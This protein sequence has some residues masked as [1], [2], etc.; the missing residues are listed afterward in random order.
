MNGKKSFPWRSL[1]SLRLEGED[2]EIP[3]SVGPPAEK[4]NIVKNDRVSRLI[5]M[6][7]IQW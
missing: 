4:F 1:L 7:R 6:C 3:L 5:R 2:I